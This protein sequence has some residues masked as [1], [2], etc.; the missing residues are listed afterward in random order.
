MHTDEVRIDG[1]LVYNIKHK[2]LKAGHAKTEAYIVR[3]RRWLGPRFH[4]GIFKEEIGPNAHSPTSK[5]QSLGV[6]YQSYI[7]ANGTSRS[8]MFR[9]R[10]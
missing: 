8:W 6:G 4:V 3:Q 1:W 10:S 5:L 7:I 2:P 9:E